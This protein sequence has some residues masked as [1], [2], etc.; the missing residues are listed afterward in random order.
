[1][2]CIV[3]RHFHH[4]TDGFEPINSGEE[5]LILKRRIFELEKI[6]ALEKIENEKLSREITILKK[7]K[8]EIK[9]PNITINEVCKT[10][11]KCE[12]PLE[13][14]CPFYFGMYNDLSKIISSL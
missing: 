10:D 3:F 2:F 13:Y 5:N 7:P 14:E 8:T 9:C 11:N 6:V 4:S 12:I 1:M